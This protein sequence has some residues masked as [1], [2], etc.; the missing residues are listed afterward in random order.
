MLRSIAPGRIALITDA[1]GATCAADGHYR[2]G[3][4]D[5]QVMTEHLQSLGC[6]EIRRTDYL[7]RVADAVE[8]PARLMRPSTL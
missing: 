8:R 7:A 4:F 2:L 6:V 1:M 3:A 5:V